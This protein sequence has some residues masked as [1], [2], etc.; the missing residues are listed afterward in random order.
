MIGCK[1][2]IYQDSKVCL[3]FFGLWKADS[4]NNNVKINLNGYKTQ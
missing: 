2:A 1:C 3:K 4:E